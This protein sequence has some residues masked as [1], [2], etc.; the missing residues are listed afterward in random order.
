MNHPLKILMLEDSIIDAELIQRLLKKWDPTCKISLSSD[1]NTF[2]KALEESSPNVILSDNSLPQFSALEALQ[3]VRQ[4][5]SQVPFILV[6]GTVS[7]EFAA[8]IIKQGA[9]DY[10]L[11]DRMSRLPSAIEFAIKQR[12]ALKEIADYRY[13]LDQS[14]IVAITD[15]K[16]IITYA[17]DN[18]CKISKYNREE[19]LGQ[20]HRILNS[21]Y[22]PKSYIKDL[23]VTIANGQI[24]RGEFRNRA[25]DGSIYWVDATVIP[26][27]NEQGKPYQYLA[28]RIDI[29]EKKRA[30]EKIQ[31]SEEQYRDLVENI[32]D[33]ICTHDLEGRI[34]SVNRAAE[35][36][37]GRKFDSADNLNIKDILAPDKKD[38]F[39]LYI[40]QLKEKGRVQGLMKV[41]SFS[42]K[43]H[44][45]EYNN[46]LKATGVNTA[47]IRGFARDITESRIAE[48]N[49][50]K[51][52]ARLKEAQSV[53]H[54]SNWEIDFVQNKVVWSDEA[55]NIYGLNKADVQPST[56]LF[57][58]MVHPD[59]ADFVNKM[60][61]EAM[62][63]FKDSSFNFR[64][65]RKDG[66]TRYG[67]N[68]W[69]FEF[70]KN[71]K[72]KR[73]YGILQDITESKKAEEELKKS[74][75]RFRY[76][77]Q[78][79]LDIIWEL[80]FETKQYLVHEGGEKLFGNKR[81]LRWNT[82]VQGKYIL[83]E[84]RERVRKSFNEARMNPACELWTDEYKVWSVEKK[85]LHIINHAIFIRDS[86]GTAVRAIG[87][88]TD[89]TEKKKLEADLL[90]QQKNE[91]LKIT[92]TTLDAQEKE[93]NA[94]A[95]ELHDNVNQILVG[96]K[97]LLSIAK[98][99][100]DQ[101]KEMIISSMDNLQNAIDENRKIA[102]ELV[103]PDVVTK[104]LDELMEDL[105]ST[106]LKTAHI[107]VHLDMGGLAENI[108]SEK[109]KLAIYRIAQEQCTNIIKYAQAK[110]VN[111]VLR[112]TGDEFIMSIADDGVGMDP[113]KKATGIGIR[114][115]NARLSVFHGTVNIETSPGNGF[116]LE[117]KIPLIT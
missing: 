51:S 50:R 62:R 70:D 32:T 30:E 117:I 37:M 66:T 82:G 59:D 23:W 114:N 38:E 14:A 76:A 42:G 36:L 33:L 85:V 68:K 40:A 22:H 75:E 97:L 63:N 103:T 25:K 16:G 8:T 9:D 89:I 79:T 5:S 64:F 52:E 19:L 112:K 24:W 71:G 86:K 67:Y 12:A 55:Y 74:N 80:N 69:K 84:D 72:P 7:D 17:N 20:D 34:L 43:I 94:I 28:I 98:T 53:A 108:L 18:F 92:S 13:A 41:K 29:T 26:F 49:L 65:M 109:Q 96:T 107:N 99:N 60:V 58:A 91:Q 39:D 102:H 6:T 4:R 48:E 110:S 81:D 78:A 35:K 45:W 95:I 2:L 11:K 21:G 3:I 54:I 105:T 90:E 101:A 106:M 31:K 113:N 83:D 104:Q 61:D 87:A 73:L 15:Q 93:R 115:M 44:I 10:I 111:I 116:K 1:K 100:P 56:E 57:L 47:I 88:I 77:A 27:F 46:S